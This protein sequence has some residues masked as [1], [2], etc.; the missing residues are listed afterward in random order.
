MGIQRLKPVGGGT[1]WSKYTPISI[2]SSITP[3]TTYTP[4]LSITGKG[5]LKSATAY[6]ARYSL[7]ITIDGTVIHESGY[8]NG[9]T[10]QQSGLIAGDDILGEGT[11]SLYD[12]LN[13]AYQLS[14]VTHPFIMSSL[15]TF[16]NKSVF[17]PKELFFKQ[18]LLVEIKTTTGIDNISYEI[19]GGHE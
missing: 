18:S 3:P 17:L 13:S 10:N 11:G 5:F 9:T 14:I 1:D 6:G 4:V 15:S 12:R 8:S 16:S 19:T 2:I 7:R